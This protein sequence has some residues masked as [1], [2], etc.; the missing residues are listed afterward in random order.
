M[1]IGFIG[2]GNMGG[3]LATAAAKS[4]NE[5][6][7]ADNDKEKCESLAKKLSAK[8]SENDAICRECDYIFLGVKPQVLPALLESISPVLAARDKKA[9]LVSMAAGVKSEYVS[10]MAGGS[11]VIR[12]M[13]N[14]PVAIGMGMVVY[15]GNEK[16]TEQDKEAFT[17]FMSAAGCLEEIDE[18][19]IDAAT[20]VSGC[21]PAFVYMFIKSL[22]DSGAAC[23][24]G[25]DLAIT[26][27][28]QTVLGAA[29][30][31][32]SSDKTPKELI[33]AVCS[34]GG[35]TIEGVRS[36]EAEDL[37]GIVSRAAE[38]S[39]KRTKELGQK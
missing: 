32:K 28:S 14:T 10:S 19:D 13:P 21:G 38:K 11:P 16:V 20:V 26:L 29:G 9:I 6:L 37:A 36:L 12:I 33:D 3:A 17:R 5:I 1:K 15:C 31:L 24:L 34:P 35:S 8:V 23:G 22:A 30:L 27:A 25:S 39:F 7:L 18:K 4:E 2:C